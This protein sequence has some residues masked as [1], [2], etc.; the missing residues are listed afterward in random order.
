MKDQLKRILNLVR[1]TGD[2][3]VVTDMEGEEAYVVMDLDQYERLLDG[4]NHPVFQ[5]PLA[6]QESWEDELPA[7]EPETSVQPE[8]ESDIWDAMQAANAQGDTWDM[9]RM[10]QQELAELEQ[11]YAAYVNKTVSEAVEEHPIEAQQLASEPEKEPKS[12]EFR[13]EQF[14]LEPIE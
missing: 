14:Y 11:Q 9:S 1:K 13:E 10:N 4:A 12:E 3:M 7:F 5:K 2:T 6:L 8:S